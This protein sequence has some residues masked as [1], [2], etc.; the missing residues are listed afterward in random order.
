[1]KAIKSD[2][3]L[4]IELHQIILQRRAIEKREQELKTFFKT[5]L[6]SL[7]VDTVTTGGILIKLVDRSRTDIDRKALMAV[8]GPDT[9]KQFERTTTYLQVDVSEMNANIL[10]NVA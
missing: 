9:V 5:K 2:T 8:L 6:S 3:T 1:M 4:A 10:R 7:G